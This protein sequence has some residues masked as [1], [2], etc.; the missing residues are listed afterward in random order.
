MHEMYCSRESAPV[1]VAPPDH[2]CSLAFT[3]T[4]TSGQFIYAKGAISAADGV[5]D[6]SFA[7]ALSRCA[8]LGRLGRLLTASMRG[9]VGV[10]GA[11]KPGE[12]LVSVLPMP[13]PLLATTVLE[14][15]VLLGSMASSTVKGE[16][17]ELF[18]RLTQQITVA[19]RSL[20]FGDRGGV[21]AL[22]YQDH[23]LK[24]TRLVPRADE[25]TDAACASC[26]VALPDDFVLCALLRASFTAIQTLSKSPGR[27][28]ALQALKHSTV[29]L[30]NWL[31]TTPG[32][33]L[34]GGLRL[35]VQ[36]A[37]LEAIF[38][39]PAC[40]LWCVSLVCRCKCFC[41]D[42]RQIRS[43]LHVLAPICPL[44]SAISL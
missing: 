31:S 6:C 10:G 13:L 30:A 43:V 27:S 40:L 38:S 32:R 22:S 18:I 19:A 25:E 20:P 35:L 44:S 36:Y 39:F 9:G 1:N 11:S 29:A 12:A 14:H 37:V 26:A 17:S 3:V 8:K 4:L 21:L 42:Q 24:I 15:P 5:E 33:S 28:T 23:A 2:P 7:S 34:C 16:D 41:C